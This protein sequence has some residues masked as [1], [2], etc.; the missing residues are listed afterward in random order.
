MPQDLGLGIIGSFPEHGIELLESVK[1]EKFL[2]KDDCPPCSLLVMG[3]VIL[4]SFLHSRLK[5]H[6]F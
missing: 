2:L 5:L 3:A 6:F 4:V 1:S